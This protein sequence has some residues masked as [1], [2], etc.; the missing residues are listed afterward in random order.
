MLLSWTGGINARIGSTPR[1]E[2][3]ACRQVC[4]TRYIRM[5]DLV[6]IHDEAATTVTGVSKLLRK[7]ESN[8][9]LMLDEWLVDDLSLQQEYFRFELIERQYADKVLSSVHSTALRTAMPAWVEASMQ[10]LSLTAS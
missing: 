5:P 10:M 2:Y 8:T 7:F 1:A 6:K 9:L 4:R 3:S